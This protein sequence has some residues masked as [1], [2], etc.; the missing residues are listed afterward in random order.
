MATW[1]PVPQTE[2]RPVSRWS[3][4]NDTPMT[5]THPL[6][7]YIPPYRILGR[8][9]DSPVFNS[10]GSGPKKDQSTAS[11]ALGDFLQRIRGSHT[12][13]VLCILICAL[14]FAL[15]TTTTV[16]SVLRVVQGGVDTS[17]GENDTQQ[18]VGI[19]NQ[20]VTFWQASCTSTRTFSIVLRL[21]INL[22]ATMLLA[23]SNYC[24]Q[25]LVSPTRSEIDLVHR[26][27]RWLWI[28]VP[29]L[30]NLPYI[31]LGRMAICLLL[32]ISTLPLHVLWN[33]ALVQTISANDYYVGG[34]TEDFFSS[35]ASFNASPEAFVPGWFKG[36]Q[37][38]FKAAWFPAVSGANVTNLTAE[39]CIRAYANPA[40]DL[41]RNVALVFDTRNGTN[42]F[43]FAGTHLIGTDDDE[44]GAAA[45]LGDSW[46]CGLP[47]PSTPACDYRA[48]ADSNSTSWTPLSNTAG[49]STV[50]S[51]NPYLEG[52]A[53]S[54]VPVKYCMAQNIN[55][56]D[57][58]SSCQL[59]ALPILQYAVLGANA[60]MLLCFVV[61]W[62][63]VR[64]RAKH[65]GEERI[66]TNGDL[67]ASYLREPDLRF[68]GRCL[69]SSRMVMKAKRER[70]H[71]DHHSSGRRRRRRGRRGPAGAAT[72]AAQVD[73][74]DEQQMEELD[75]DDENEEEEEDG[76]EDTTVGFWN[77]SQP[78]P[79]PWT[80]R[81]RR[82]T[83]VLGS[84]EKVGFTLERGDSHGSAKPG[85]GC[86]G[87]KPDAEQTTT[88][89]DE[90]GRKS[91]PRWHTGV[92]CLVAPFLPAILIVLAVI[93][94]FFAFRLQNNL[95]PGSFGQ[96]SAQTI[97]GVP[98][99]LSSSSSTNTWGTAASALVA[100]IPQ[101]VAVYVYLTCNSALTTMLAHAEV[102][103][104][105]V[106][107]GGLRVSLP[108]P[109]SAQRSTFHLHLPLHLSLP[110]LLACAAL[111]WLLGESLFL[112]RVAVYGSDSGD[113][114]GNGGD[115]QPRATKTAVG[116]A[117]IPILATA[118]LLALLVGI[119]L[120]VGWLK[121]YM[122][123][124]RMPL[125]ATCS[126]SLAAATCPTSSFY[127]PQVVFAGSGGG[128]RGGIIAAADPAASLVP[129]QRRSRVGS[130]VEAVGLT[131][132]TTIT[133][134]AAPTPSTAAAA[135]A[136][137]AYGNPSRDEMGVVSSAFPDPYPVGSYAYYRVRRFEEKLSEHGLAWGTVDDREPVH[138]AT[139]SLGPVLPLERGQ[140]YA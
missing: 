93:G 30:G 43:L 105:A 40:V 95:S 116:Y 85:M 57:S 19:D 27:K 61:T 62:F 136:G 37:E 70:N 139:F 56:D 76:E 26:K 23:C 91:A 122:G 119:V 97:A 2:Q 84:H 21:A 31:G 24:M 41:Y 11:D 63:T 49:W 35:G 25:I 81:M 73:G 50:A 14:V 1:E 96:P 68:A 77:S 20:V 52:L 103:R 83:T 54:N 44:N 128:R 82:R 115:A 131:T 7:A 71:R 124:E 78:M 113:G 33:S 65:E 101:L 51:S 69:A 138:H 114:G 38:R 80:G 12:G 137:M 47:A 88:T 104:F 18:P 58:P 90:Q 92:P 106:R 109:D 121:R 133:R 98:A 53:K 111:H 48:L 123:A 16:F 126:A 132:T 79:L 10:R 135:A 46:V 29:N 120:A 100:N 112:L 34:V 28:G 118:G 6:N 8:L 87:Q 72:Q 13:V 39:D 102:S 74:D 36:R 107:R 45:G 127:F 89:M 60:L 59:A 15:N 129:P 99:Q 75:L 64:R 110:V 22:I 66:V 125:F 94:L 130:W 32:I 17:L 5:G 4:D 9:W 86:F 67:I 140:F 55:A 117:A 42:S 3:E 108:R 134:S